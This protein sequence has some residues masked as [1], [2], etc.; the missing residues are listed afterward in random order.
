MTCSG[1]H[2]SAGGEAGVLAKVKE[3]QVGG[4][5]AE[6]KQQQ[7]RREYK[8]AVWMDREASSDPQARC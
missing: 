3:K 4:R 5:Q 8:H 7:R 2:Q 6:E 1:V